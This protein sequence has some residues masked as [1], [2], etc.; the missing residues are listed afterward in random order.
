[1]K[2]GNVMTVGSLWQNRD[3]VLTQIVSHFFSFMRGGI[4]M[5]QIPLHVLVWAGLVFFKLFITWGK[6]C[7]MGT[8]IGYGKESRDYLDA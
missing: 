5:E 7:W 6:I 3:H 4:I 1:M 8:S 2:V